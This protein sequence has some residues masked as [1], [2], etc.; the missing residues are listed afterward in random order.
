[1]RLASA[2]D[3]LPGRRDSRGG[4]S[5]GRPRRAEARGAP[6]SGRRR[7]GRGGR[8]R[9][10]EGHSRRH[11]SRGRGRDRDSLGAEPRGR[12]RGRGSARPPGRH[13]A[14]DRALRFFDGLVRQRALVFVATIGLML[15]GLVAAGKLG[16]GIYPEFEFPRIVVVVRA[17]DLP[18]EEIQAAVVRPLEESLATVLGLR[19]L[20]VRIIRGAA[21]L[22]LQFV[23]D[24]DMWRALQLVDAAAADAR[25]NLPPGVE[26]ETQKVTPADFPILSYNLVGGN[27]TIRREAAEQ[28]VRPVFSRVPGV[29][30]VE[31]LGGDPREVEVVADPARLAAA[32]IRPAELARRVGEGLARRA[33]GRFDSF[34]QTTTGLA[35]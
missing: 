34:R 4:A 25:S 28:L 29:G 9:E 20:R 18:P 21:E 15:A 33:V 22:S 1:R 8:G 26:I 5:E 10:G 11:G 32:G 31:V 3:R 23:D 14:G 2:R 27:A 35:A 6:R 30:R 16:S 17:A 19:R 7:R 24:A 12:R 13:E